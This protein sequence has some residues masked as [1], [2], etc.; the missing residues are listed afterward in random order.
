MNLKI[1]KF[2][3]RKKHPIGINTNWSERKHL[4]SYPTP[5]LKANIIRMLGAFNYESY[6]ITPF[7]SG[8]F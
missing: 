2:H 1:T 6:E 7:L 5:R 3:T 4:Q 8:K